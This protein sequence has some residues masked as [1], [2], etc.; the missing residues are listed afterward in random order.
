MGRIFPG[1]FL[2]AIASLLLGA[3]TLMD[4]DVMRPWMELEI[5][6]ARS[7][8]VHATSGD[9]SAP[10]LADE[11]QY[12][13]VRIT[14]A[15]ARP[16]TIL[17]PDGYRADSRAVTA[18]LVEQHLEPL[19]R[20]VAGWTSFRVVGST[21]HFYMITFTFSQDR[22]PDT[23]VIQS[24]G[25]SAPHLLGTPTGFTSTFPIKQSSLEAL[26]GPPTRVTRRRGI[27]AA[28]CE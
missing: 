20:T 27:L 15:S 10:S 1:Q 3:C 13:Y 18:E 21:R 2:I 12:N 8:V 14:L 7:S 6:D 24:C 26:F 11:L 4:V 19:K 23:L 9:S 17:F 5:D 25:A 16:F 22:R 28:R